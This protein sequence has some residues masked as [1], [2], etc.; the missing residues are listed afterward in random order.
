MADDDCLKELR[1]I[2][3]GRDTQ[4]AQREL[5]D[6]IAKWQGKYPKLVNWVE[7]NGVQ[8]LNFYRLSRA[9][10]KYLK[11][12]NMLA[13]LNE[14]FKRRTRVDRIFCERPIPPAPD[15]GTVRRT[16]R[17]LA[18]GQTLLEHDAPGG[19]EKGIADTGRLKRPPRYHR[20]SGL[21]RAR[22]GKRN[23]INRSHDHEFAQIRR[24]QL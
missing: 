21:R 16:P 11:S 3:N 24:T 6:W 12:T 20:R 1:W 23:G 18:G 15:P 8:A 22:R 14:E 13:R 5:A 7:A 17:L 4:E 2:Y 19:A 9:H 10:H